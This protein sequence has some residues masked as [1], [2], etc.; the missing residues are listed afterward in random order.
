[1]DIEK[2]ILKRIWLLENL[3]NLLG[4]VGY[5]R[6]HQSTFLNVGPPLELWVLDDVSGE[7]NVAAG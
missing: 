3:Q 4:E 2:R 5:H 1:M 6:E 7:V